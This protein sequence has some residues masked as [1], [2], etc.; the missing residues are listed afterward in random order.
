MRLNSDDRSTIQL[1]KEDEKN[2]NMYAPSEKDIAQMKKDVN[3][4][5]SKMPVPLDVVVMKGTANEA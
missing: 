2:H 3:G 4:L 1:I 5:K